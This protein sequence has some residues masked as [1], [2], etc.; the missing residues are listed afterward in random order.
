[1]ELLLFITL[2]IAIVALIIAAISFE[3]FFYLRRIL[4]KWTDK[5]RS[6]AVENEKLWKDWQDRLREERDKHLICFHDPIEPRTEVIQKTYAI[7]PSLIEEMATVQITTVLDGDALEVILENVRPGNI[8]DIIKDQDIFED[9]D[10]KQKSI[11]FNW[12]Y[13]IEF[14]IN[15]KTYL[16][17]GDGFYQNTCKF[18][19]KL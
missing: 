14:Y 6:E 13:E 10:F 7:T 19:L 16:L 8:I 9:K 18:S 1:M 4:Q 5:Q 12:D 17:E 15:G 2:L 11:G 3:R